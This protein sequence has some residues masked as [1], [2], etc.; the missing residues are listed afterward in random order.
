MAAGD[1]YEFFRQFVAA[2]VET[3]IVPVGWDPKATDGHL[4]VSLRSTLISLLARFSRSENTVEEARKRYD[5]Y[6]ANPDDASACPSDYR[7]SVFSIVL[8][9]G[10]EAEFNTVQ[11]LYSTLGSNVDKKMVLNAIGMTDSAALKIRALDWATSGAILLQD[12]FYAIYSVGGSSPEGTK[13]AWQYFQDNFERLRGMVANASPSLFGAVIGG[14][15]SGFVTKEAAESIRSFFEANPVPQ[16][17][18]LIA[19]L[20]ES[21]LGNAGF[22]ERLLASKLVDEAYWKAL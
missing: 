3:A 4:T 5:A 10:G 16:N 9:A 12:F 8:R 6:V 19:Q 7:V 20:L 22:A 21:I 15:T 17:Q 14:S 2:M 13:V 1:T 11:G 18:R